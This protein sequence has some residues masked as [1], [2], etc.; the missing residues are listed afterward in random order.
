MDRW[1]FVAFAGILAVM[2]CA[3]GCSS[4]KPRNFRDMLH[5][6]PVVRAGAVGL[7]ENQPDSV[8]IPAWIQPLDDKEAV[9]QAGTPGVFTIPH[10]DG[11]PAVLV[12]LRVVAKPALRAL[13]VDGWLAGAPSSLADEFLASPRGRR[14]R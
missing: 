7:G 9:L 6:A 4:L 12:Q 14:H 2:S 1:R 13:V 5:P 11:Y 3:S 10:F 8:A